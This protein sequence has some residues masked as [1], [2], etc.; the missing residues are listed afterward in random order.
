[1]GGVANASANGGTVS[2]GDVNSNGSGNTS[3]SVSANGGTA[4]ANAAGGNNNVAQ[5][6]G[7]GGQPA[8][9]AQPAQPPEPSVLTV[10]LDGHVAPGRPMTYWLDTDAGRLPAPGPSLV[11]TDE[12]APDA[13]AI[14]VV[15]FACSVPTAQSGFDWFGQCQTPAAGLPFQV[16][17]QAGSST[18]PVATG[19]TND[20]GR[21]RFPNLPPGTYQ[22]APS[23]S[24]W[25][26]A[27]SD[28]V[29]A[30]GNVVVKA[31]AD[32][33]IWIFTCT[34]GGS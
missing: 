9:A 7:N 34:P 23:G 29:D 12:T 1:N 13:G 21:I 32:S 19:T 24:A 3:V 5:A 8:V 18:T 11:Q 10:V 30:Q 4:N 25:C 27:E 33:N 6:G 28:S 15:G 20:R 22:L 17:D 14:S 2:I 26:H 31:G 16:F